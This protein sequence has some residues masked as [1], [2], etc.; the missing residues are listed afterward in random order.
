MAEASCSYHSDDEKDISIENIESDE[1]SLPQ[2]DLDAVPCGK[3]TY[4]KK[5]EE[6]ERILD[7]QHS[8][9]PSLSHS[10][11]SG[12]ERKVWSYGFNLCCL[13]YQI[14]ELDLVLK[15]KS[16]EYFRFIYPIVLLFSVLV[17]IFPLLRAV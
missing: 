7:N 11:T 14:T 13:Y 12:Y 4:C 17:L 1:E 6:S 9:L 16:D 15:L 2:H 8:P 10:Q 5:T 3:A